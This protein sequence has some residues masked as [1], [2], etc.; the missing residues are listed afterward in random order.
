MHHLNI[1]WASLLVTGLSFSTYADDNSIVSAQSKTDALNNN[2][3]N[4]K[5]NPENTPSEIDDVRLYSKHPRI[6]AL[7]ELKGIKIDDL[8]VNAS[9][10]QADEVKDPLQPLNRQIYDLNNFLDRTVARPLAIQY[11]KKVPTEVRGSY[12]GFRKN[13]VEPW[14]A[15]NQVAQGRFARAAK[16]LG[17][18]TINTVTTLGLADPASRLGLKSE[19]ESLGTT[20]GY[21][22]VPSGAYLMLPVL[23]PSTLRDTAGRIVDRQG[24]L[25]SYLYEDSDRLNYT[26]SFVGG[27]DSRSKLLE[28]EDVL[29]GDRYA[30]IRDIYLQ[31]KAFEIA[32][33]KG[34]N[35]SADLFIDVVEDDEGTFIE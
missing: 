18:F 34:L 10:A 23:G 16:T 9:A 33:K 3:G 4:S 35:N 11:V 12:R 30:A 19:E 22:G 26:D 28:I 7:R 32:E 29:Q 1:F 25:K 31:R 15:V 8:K 20:L 13:L 14:N 17:R 2:L 6:E 24:D 21:Y 5:I 27:I